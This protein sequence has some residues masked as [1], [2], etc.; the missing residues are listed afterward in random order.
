MFLMSS[1]ASDG[2]AF[3]VVPS[4]AGGL[5]QN[6][7]HQ[8]SFGISKNAGKSKGKFIA[9]EFATRKWDNVGDVNGN[10]VGVDVGS[11]MSTKIANVSSV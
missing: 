1:N 10:H 3:V 8:K 4:G 11:F 6:F 9:I 7:D 2:I 5:G